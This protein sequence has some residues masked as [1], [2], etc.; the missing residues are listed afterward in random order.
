M[1]TIG[2]DLFRDRNLQT[3]EGRIQL[4]LTN[5]ADAKLREHPLAEAAY[6]D[7]ANSL[8]RYIG[9]LNAVV[10][11]SDVPGWLAVM[12][13]RSMILGDMK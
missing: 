2:P 11:R 5:A 9:E 8:R 10:S 12:R 4:A 3:M 13:E 6:R 1:A 7:E